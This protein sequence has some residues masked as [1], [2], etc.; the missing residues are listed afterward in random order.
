[1]PSELLLPE[2]QWQDRQAFAAALRHLG[3]MFA[4]N[5][6]QFA[7][8]GGVVGQEL[9]ARILSG[10]PQQQPAESACLAGVAAAHV[11]AAQQPPQQQQQQQH[12]GSFWAAG[13][14]PPLTAS[15]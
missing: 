11:Q 4:A 9:V 14:R 1:V 13:S 2:L 15:V 12:Q 7:D 5:F 6:Q 10:G 3:V 8:G